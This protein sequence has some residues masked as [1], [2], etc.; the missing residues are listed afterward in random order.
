MPYSR[1]II[2][3]KKAEANSGGVEWG[4]VNEGRN[5][6]RGEGNAM[7]WRNVAQLRSLFIVVLPRVLQ[8]LYEDIYFVGMDR[9]FPFYSGCQKDLYVLRAS[10]CTHSVK[11]AG[12]G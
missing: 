8:F 9:C 10:I 1:R 11:L 5:E 3:S 2:F 12:F 6:E 7:K 4:R